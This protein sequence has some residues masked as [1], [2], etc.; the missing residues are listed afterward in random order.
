[1]KRTWFDVSAPQMARALA[2][3]GDLDPGLA[4]NLETG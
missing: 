2:A 4:E 3:A 1:M